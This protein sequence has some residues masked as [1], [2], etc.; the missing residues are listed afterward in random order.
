MIERIS[1]IGMI[2][3]LFLV[4]HALVYPNR[5]SLI[6]AILGYVIALTSA[7]IYG[8][9]KSSDIRQTHLEELSESSFRVSPINVTGATQ[10]LLLQGLPTFSRSAQAVHLST[11][12]LLDDKI[13][14]ELDINK[15]AYKIPTTKLDDLEML[16]KFTRATEIEEDK[17]KEEIPGY[18]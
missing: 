8:L 5:F 13:D 6:I 17:Y 1:K 3:S 14:I 18:Q 7:V 4:A 16:R 9:Y 11:R 15:I 10:R 2:I 12:P